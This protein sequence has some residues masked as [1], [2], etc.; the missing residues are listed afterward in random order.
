MAL[1]NVI[2]ETGLDL[3]N[4][5]L[6]QDVLAPMFAERLE[7]V[8]PE[9][10]EAAQTVSTMMKVYTS[11][12]AATTVAGAIG[13]AVA[14]VGAAKHYLDGQVDKKYSENVERCQKNREDFVKA[15]CGWGSFWSSAI[16]S[17]KS[18]SPG[19]LDIKN[20]VGG[21][22]EADFLN[23]YS[24][25]FIWML[26]KT[27]R[28]VI[29]PT[30]PT[31]PYDSPA[32]TPDD[33]G[34][35]IKFPGVMPLSGFTKQIDLKITEDDPDYL[36]PYIRK[37]H[38]TVQPDLPAIPSDDRYKYWG[39]AP[40]DGT[41]FANKHDTVIFADG[42]GIVP[43]YHYLFSWGTY[44]FLGWQTSSNAM[45]QAAAQYAHTAAAAALAAAIHA[46]TIVHA[47]VEA[48]DVERCYRNWLKS[49]GLRLLPARPKK[50]V[51]GGVY[52][53]E[54]GLPWCPHEYGLL[55]AYDDK[56]K[57]DSPYDGKCAPPLWYPV[58]WR[59]ARA[60]ELSFRSF[61]A[62]RRAVLYQID[63]VS[64]SFRKAAEKSRDAELRKALKSGPPPYEKWDVRDPLG[65]NKQAAKGGGDKKK[66]SGETKPDDKKTDFT[67]LEAKFITPGRKISPELVALIAAGGGLALLGWR[68][69]ARLLQYVQRIRGR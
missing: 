42:F 12:A 68:E 39:N 19:S 7:T 38:L 20:N 43:H 9:F 17:V 14:A 3:S 16:C 34:N 49:T 35:G 21:W 58:P 52:L 1:K 59:V 37:V 57:S 41:L 48:V 69:R 67:P 2:E 23:Q 32:S 24:D 11:L 56:C 46:P 27:G 63:K 15:Y 6:L 33:W 47:A 51:D 4:P 66:A 30:W 13:A 44:P 45:P 40:G 53:D 5:Q 61:F 64:E 60:I 54:Q 28:N 10:E 50:Q 18:P 36:D 29:V 25:Y 26:E 8:F 22:S 55:P 65:D 62:V 31:P